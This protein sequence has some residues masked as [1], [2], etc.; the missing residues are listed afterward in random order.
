MFLKYFVMLFFLPIL[1]CAYDINIAVLANHG[2]AEGE[3]DW[4]PT[5]K[6]LN[7][8]LPGSNFKLLLFLPNHFS[9]MKKKAKDGEVDFLIL[10]PSMQIDVEHSSIL[11][12]LV[13]HTKNGDISQ[14]G[15]VIISKKTS[16]INRLSQIDN[17]K[18]IGAVAPM[19]FAGWL[20]AYD[21]LTKNRIKFDKKKVLF[22]GTQ[23][24]VIEAVASGR[25][26][27]GVIR[28]GVLERLKKEKKIDISDIKV[29]NKKNYKNFPFVVSSKLYP[30]WAFAKTKKADVEISREV[31]LS[32][33]ELSKDSNITANEGYKYYWTVPH[34][35]KEVKN[36]MRRLEIGPY[37]NLNSIL[38][39]E[40]IESHRWTIRAVLALVF[41]FLISAFI[42][43]LY[44]S[45]K[46]KYLA[47]HDRLTGLYNSGYLEKTIKPSFQYSLIMLNINNLNYINIAYSFRV[48]DKIL[49]SVA[50]ILK[51]N[52]GAH[53]VY[54]MNSDQFALLYTSKIDFEKIIQEIRH[55]FHKEV[56]KFDSIQFHIS[57]S[58][59]AAYGN[60]KLVLNCILALRQAKIRGK[61][62]YHVF[63]EKSDCEDYEKT[64][65][66]IASH[67]QLFNALKESRIV[68]FFQ[69]IRDNQT[70]KT[71]KF[72]ALARME[73]D[74]KI[75]SPFHFLEA[76][77]LAGVLP[78]ITKIMIDKTFKLM[79]DND[80]TVSINITEEDL[81]KN[82]LLDY[83]NKKS[84]EYSVKSSRIILEILEGV[85]NMGQK[86][87]VAQLQK[88]KNSG[89]KLAIDDFGA[90]YSNFERTLDLNIDFVKI[91]AKY[92]KDIDTNEKSYNIVSSIVFFAKKSGIKC[93]AEFVHNRSVQ[94]VIEKLGIE[95]SQGY[96]FSEPSKKFL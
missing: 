15:S 84:L 26:E 42:H 16:N 20:I 50:D 8:K 87:N 85:S 78:S 10:P 3:R 88:L 6:Y 23:E 61:D 60:E 39:N 82:Y 9:E 25:V 21:M 91:D 52:F 72:E 18:Y 31:V 77:K 46:I 83:L 29:L 5:I 12:T 41:L 7:K 24:K 33:L 49:T 69:G 92:I 59:G 22:L 67:N 43:V 68:P 4:T 74:S 96:Y 51:N 71:T 89:Y 79:T 32:L 94:I 44:N 65:Y 70:E 11:L 36:L 14:F 27:I 56:I 28:T 81:N 62:K 66:F 30:E 93:V 45:K 76:A 95:F 48:G 53:S 34:D 80:Y 19:G 54:R 90:E 37:E 75:L 35:Y 63:N 73:V 38:I 1:L 47:Y 64:K 17:T 13:K 55:F 2:I 86:N 40:W 57:H 58:Y